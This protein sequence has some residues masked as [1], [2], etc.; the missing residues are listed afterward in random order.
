[1][2]ESEESKQYAIEK[3]KEIKRAQNEV[4]KVT[5][6]IKDTT[7]FIENKQDEMTAVFDQMLNETGIY[8]KGVDYERVKSRKQRENTVATD[9]QSLIQ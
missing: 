2:Q 6:D 3:I 9:I 4:S 7:E 5:K 1:M 8:V